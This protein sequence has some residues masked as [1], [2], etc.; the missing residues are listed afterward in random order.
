MVE[1]HAIS[2]AHKKVNP[3]SQSFY[4]K[5]TKFTHF[6]ENENQNEIIIL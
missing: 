2:S 3:T 4:E 6:Y 1:K 5:M